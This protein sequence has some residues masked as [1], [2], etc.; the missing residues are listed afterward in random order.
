LAELDQAAARNEPYA[1][2]VF[3]AGMPAPDGFTL[4]RRALR[5]PGLTGPVVLLLS[6]PDRVADVGRCRTLGVAGHLGKPVKPSDLLETLLTALGQPGLRRPDPHMEAA[7]LPVSRK[8]RVLLAEDH[9]IN[10]RLAI[11]LLQKRGHTVTVAN[12]GREAVDA[13]EREDFDVVLMDVA[14]P[15]LGGFEATALVR[16]REKGTGR[17]L[18]IVA[19]TAHAMKGD[20]DQCLEAGMDA[21]LAKPLQER[22]LC[23]LL[24]TMF[25]PDE[26]AEDGPA[27][28]D[29]TV[30]LGNAG[31]D[32][33]LC[34]E[35]AQLFVT[36]SAK[37][38]T[39]LGEAIAL[40]DST[41]V[42]R[43]AHTLKGA[44]LT[45]AAADAQEA[46]HALEKMG[47]AGTWDGVEEVWGTLKREIGRL[48]GALERFRG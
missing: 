30:A 24:A 12:N 40:R 27:P 21:Y 15:E 13:I 38:L 36:E 18:P 47:R 34:R 29:E 9:I 23:A 11:A 42:H 41:T 46:A 31:G 48:V 44:T 1:A 25:P 16:E 7:P 20:R 45:F 10:Q 4:A 28:F 6:S 14:M 17:R 8:L 35:L 2:A 19:V 33:T 37:L 26:E 43:V 5:H 39:Q 22:E 3:D 32:P